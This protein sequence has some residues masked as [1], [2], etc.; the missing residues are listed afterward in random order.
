MVTYFAKYA[1]CCEKCQRHELLTHSPTEPLTT[2]S[3]TYP[4]MRWAM[5][6]ARPL[7]S[8]PEKKYILIM[9]DYFKKWVEAKSYA[10]IQGIDIHKFVWKNIICR[11]G[12]PYE[13]VTDNGKQF[14]SN[15][16]EGFCARWQ[17]R[18]SK[19]TLHYLQGNGQAEATNKTILDG[20]K[21][22][23]E[24]IREHGPTSWMKFY[25]PIE[26]LRDDIQVAHRFLYH[27]GLKQ[28]LWQKLTSV[29][30]DK[31]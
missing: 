10:K 13:I 12:L 25:G 11:H 3:A 7:R 26:L 23:L 22:H 16:F 2:S 24:K 1:K 4:F 15:V 21:K 29:F 5:D 17:T 8:S 27:M 6:I 19:S 14:T 9:T 31:P 30:Y 28:W 18:L 20:L